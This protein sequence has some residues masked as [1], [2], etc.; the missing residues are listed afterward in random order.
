MGKPR[1]L[2][3]RDGRHDSQATTFFWMWGPPLV[4][5]DKSP[6][7]LVVPREGIYDHAVLW[8]SLWRF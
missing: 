3:R 6:S 4:F 1:A 7:S 5:G 8:S 2:R